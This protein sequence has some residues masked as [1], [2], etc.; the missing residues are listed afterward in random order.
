MKL[1]SAPCE[2]RLLHRAPFFV[3]WVVQAANLR[4]MSLSS[5]GITARIVLE[6][7]NVR[8]V[9]ARPNVLAVTR[10]MK[11]VF[12][13]AVCVVLV[14]L[15]A[16]APKTPLAPK[17]DDE[18]AK[19]FV[20]RSGLGAI[21]VFRKK[22]FRDRQYLLP[23]SLDNQ[24]IGHISEYEYL[25][26]DVMPGRHIVTIKDAANIKAD[27]LNIEADTIAFVEFL[28]DGDYRVFRSV[29]EKDG[30]N[31]IKKRDMARKHIAGVFPALPEKK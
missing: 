14:A 22:Q 8:A 7:Q 31:A 5:F 9:A 6:L 27:E 2:T 15:V 29:N 30:K 25:R 3:F 13:L 24:L 12:L 20:A 28:N 4:R 18:L 16:C 23:V 19:Q 1:R 26:I 21:Y 10:F 17:Q 11:K